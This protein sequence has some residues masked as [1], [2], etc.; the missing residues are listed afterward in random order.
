[1]AN[2]LRYCILLLFASVAF[3]SCI[4][5]DFDM[6][7]E[8]G[9][10]AAITDGY[11]LALNV[12]LDKMGGMSATRADADDYNPMEEV[13]NYVNPEKF[14]VLFFDSQY[15]FLFESKSRWV[16]LL[17]Q[18]A[19]KTSWFVSIPIFS[20]GNDVKYDWPWE[21]IRKELTTKDS[22][23]DPQK[24]CFYIAI[25]ANRP[26]IECFP[27]LDNTMKGTKNFDNAGPHWELKNTAGYAEEKKDY[28]NVKSVFDLHHCQWDPIYTSKNNKDVGKGQTGYYEI[29]MGIDPKP[30][31]VDGIKKEFLMGATSCW[32]DHGPTMTDDGVKDGFGNR[33][34]IHPSKD[35]PIPMY[36]IQRFTK[37]PADF[38]TTGT[39]FNLSEIPDVENN[40][41]VYK[42]YANISLLRSVVKLELRIPIKYRQPK[43]VCLTYSNIYARC[44]PMDVWTPT[45]LLWKD[46]DNGCEWKTIWEHDLLSRNQN[47]AGT[48][49][50]DYWNRL[51][52][53]YG[54]WM[55]TNPATNE[56]WWNFN[57]DKS[58]GSG[59]STTG[60]VNSGCPRIFN[61]CIQRNQRVD[62][63][64]AMVEDDKYYHY[65][66]YTGERNVNDPSDLSA[67]NKHGTTIY[68][69]VSFDSDDSL[70]YNIDGSA[71]SIPIGDYTYRNI[72][73]AA[74]ENPLIEVAQTENTP[75][76]KEETKNGQTVIN[77]NEF[78]Q[79]TYQLKVQNGTIDKKYRPYPL[80]RN[81]VYTLTLGSTDG[82]DFTRAGETNLT[83][84]S[85]ER[86][87]PT[88][89]FD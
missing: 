28:S 57:T 26:T 30:E 50:L 15:R 16:K 55:D 86:H 72:N 14:R 47:D 82:T 80:L 40:K 61:P 78:L 81:H 29:V 66:V 6:E 67:I 85:E 60:K 11:S 13:E 23:V 7:C 36:G 75:F 20:Y 31:T 18:D 39:P 88:I 89:K 65:V 27:D 83:I 17:S 9:V 49:K 25:L 77:T 64:N 48:S 41:G 34:A 32:V 51:W 8:Y 43:Y 73:T 52:W 53:F 69:Y 58:Q 42:D 68:W 79:K 45:D 3:V 12:T 54:A 5:E 46:H 84:T 76:L 19:D 56:P 38:W 35:Y 70:P 2:R 71:F 74:A 24:D 22:D 62:C 63:T 87:S 59:F 37:I 1:M 21:Q 33:T 4:Y 44:E 10:P